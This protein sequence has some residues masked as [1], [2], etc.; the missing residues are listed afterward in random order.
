[1]GPG[2]AQPNRRGTLAAPQQRQKPAGSGTRGQ[3]LA[4][5]KEAEIQPRGR[6]QGVVAC[7]EDEAGCAAESDEVRRQTGIRSLRAHFLTVALPYRSESLDSKLKQYEKNR[8]KLDKLAEATGVRKDS[9]TD[10][11]QIQVGEKCQVFSESAGTYV[12]AQVIALRD[13]DEEDESAVESAEVQVQYLGADGTERQRWVSVAS[14][15]FRRAGVED[16]SEDAK[17]AAAEELK[18]QRERQRYRL[19]PVEKQRARATLMRVPEARKPEML[20]E[21]VAWTYSADVFHGL[22]EKERKLLCMEAQGELT[23]RHGAVVS[24]GEAASGASRRP[25]TS[26]LAGAV[27]ERIL[28]VSRRDLHHHVGGV[29][30]LHDEKD[31]DALGR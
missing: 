11:V 18:Y 31:G 23:P 5:G 20:K 10:A 2:S 1:M 4:Q 27:T 14:S 13:R 24:H 3:W 26:S 30:H 6:A 21:L 29:R 8:E 25:L 19:G 17:A 7:G 12:E 16:E 22:S 15:E 28:A 9:E